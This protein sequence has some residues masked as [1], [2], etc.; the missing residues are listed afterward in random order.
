MTNVRLAIRGLTKFIFGAVLVGLLL[1]L[2]AGSLLYPNAWLFMGLLF[3]PILILGTVLLIK[4][5]ALLEKRLDSKEEDGAQK[6][7][8]ALSGLIFIAGFVVAGLDYRLG[9]SDVPTWVVVTASCILLLSYALYAEVMRENTY[10][11]RKIEVSE[12]QKVVDTGLYSVVRHPMY[13]VTVW[14]FLSIPVVLGSWWS[15]LCFSP[16]VIVIAVRIVNEEK[17]LVAQLQGYSDYRKRVK[18]RLIPFVW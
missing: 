1:F 17:L 9:W 12:G 3:I 16:Y 13:A 10:L 4:S 15:L 11:S 5:P 14:L 6:V 8:V 2:P 7:F 18:Y